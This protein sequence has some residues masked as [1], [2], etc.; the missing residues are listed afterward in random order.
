MVIH[1]TP[2]PP[3]VS[4]MVIHPTPRPP[5]GQP[6]LFWADSVVNAAE[7][8]VNEHSCDTCDTF[9]LDDIIWQWVAIWSIRDVG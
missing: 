5:P 2:R 4:P 9:Y 7:A 8:E 6:I 3:Q 1:P